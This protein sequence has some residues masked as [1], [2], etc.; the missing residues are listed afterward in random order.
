MWRLYFARRDP[1]APKK[2]KS[3]Y[4]QF[5]ADM[6]SRLNKDT[7]SVQG[8]CKENS[9]SE[10]AKLAR[11]AWERERNDK[12]KQPYFDKASALLLL[13]ERQI[14]KYLRGMPL[15]GYAM[16][17]PKARGLVTWQRQKLEQCPKP[18]WKPHVKNIL[19]D[20]YTVFP[21]ILS[22]STIHQFLYNK[23][24]YDGSDNSQN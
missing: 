1:N 4:C 21:K 15:G 22:K 18:E 10:L 14:D 13:Y 7:S 24:E 23:S 5:Y 11:A 8:S 16:P 6:V 12:Q 20:G 19:E 3:A 2:S 17:P 9:R